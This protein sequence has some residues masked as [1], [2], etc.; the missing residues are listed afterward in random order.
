MAQH[1]QQEKCESELSQ[2]IRRINEANT[3]N[4]QLQGFISITCPE[5]NRVA[6]WNEGFEE[7]ATVKLKNHTTLTLLITF[8]YKVFL[9]YIDL[10]CVNSTTSESLKCTVTWYCKRDGAWMKTYANTF[11]EKSKK[12]LGVQTR[13]IFQLVQQPEHG[14][15]AA[16]EWKIA[17][18]NIKTNQQIGKL[19][20]KVM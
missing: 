18:T 16:T 13:Y 8:A 15:F 6:A 10:H 12:S 4:A 9:Y 11:D 7:S 14:G 1:A 3:T 2:Y 5:A 20:F 17:I 19:G